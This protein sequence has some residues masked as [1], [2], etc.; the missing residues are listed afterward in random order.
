MHILKRR[1]VVSLAVIAAFAL[2]GMALA[3]SEGDDTVVNYGYDQESHFF[4][5]N[6]TS[7]DYEPDTGAL[8]ETMDGYEQTQLTALLDECGLAAPQGSDEIVYTYEVG[9]DGTITILREGT[10]VEGECGE[11]N[12]GDVTGPEG[13][14]NHGMFLKFFNEH[15][16]GE[17]RGC[18]VS[19]IARSGLGM[20][21]QQVKAGGPDTDLDES[22]ASEG[23][24]SPEITFTTVTT[25]CQ[26]G[27]GE[28]KKAEDT[29][30][31]GED[32]KDK[33]RGP[34]SRR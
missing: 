24:E 13:Q 30:D 32:D 21:Y 31:D 22:E 18:I 14:V 33:R 1:F 8:Q 19:Q 4:I 20:D 25:E 7:L 15:Y 9:D 10:L 28:T 3:A 17:N 29:E 2:S 23:D 12:G 34:L 26:R 16:E 5:W 11:F 27:K 6:V